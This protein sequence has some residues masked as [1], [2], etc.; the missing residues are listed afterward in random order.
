MNLSELLYKYFGFDSFRNAQQEIIQSLIEGN[1]TLVVMPTGGGKSLCYQLTSLLFQGTALVVSPLIALMKDQVDSLNKRNIPAA[2]LNSSQSMSEFNFTLD[3]ALNNKYKLL[4][5]APER[6]DS[7]RFQEILPQLNVSFLAVDE[8]HCISEWGHDFRPSYLEI[9][10]IRSFIPHVKTIA[11]TATATPEVQDDII[12]KLKINDAQR[13]IRGFDRANLSYRTIHVQ[14]KFEEL[15]KILKKQSNGSTIIYCGTRKKVEEYS[16]MLS[17]NSFANTIYHAGLADPIRKKNQDDFISGKQKIILATNAFGMGIDKPDV[18]NVIHLDMTQTLEAYYQEAGRAGRDGMP[19]NCYILFHPSDIFLQEFFINSTYP[20]KDDIEAL[21]ETIYDVHSAKIGQKPYDPII[22]DESQL[23]NIAG[24]KVS[25]VHSI[26]NLFE[27]YGV[28][29]KGATEGPAYIKFTTS[30][31]RIKEYFENTTDDRK[32]VLDPLLRCINSEAFYRHAS[33][34]MN[35][36]MQKYFLNWEEIKKAI[37]A[38]ENARLLNFIPPATPKG[39]VLAMERM[40]FEHLPIDFDEFYKRKKFAFEK[41][42]K[43]K[44]Y[45]DSLDCKRNFILDYFSDDEYEG[46]CAICSSCDA[47]KKELKARNPKNDFILNRILELV[48]SLDIKVGINRLTETLMGKKSAYVSKIDLSKNPLYGSLKE[49]AKGEIGSEIGGAMINGYLTKSNDQYQTI[50]ITAKGVSLIKVLP[51][52][53]V[54]EKVEM[55]HSKD[56][57]EKIYQKLNSLREEIAD[58]ESVVPRAIISTATLKKLARSAPEN[59]N[60]LKTVQGLGVIFI[61]RF[62]EKFIDAI[63]DTVHNKPKKKVPDVKII[64]ITENERA[65]KD[66]FDRGRN[67]QYIAANIG[68]SEGEIANSIIEMMDKNVNFIMEKQAFMNYYSK[69]KILMN[70]SSAKTLK[71]LSEKIDGDIKMSELKVL[72]HLIKLE[73]IS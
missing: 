9:G 39:I 64:K 21:Y 29:R 54:S 23:G 24:L 44:Q 46:K 59:L 43:V 53:F 57:S 7:P 31:E 48:Y 22:L 62:G 16:S 25:A 42:K 2:F 63:I 11:L 67:I 34:D 72:V 5:I 1:D 40:D 37:K 58:M 51:K 70:Y 55:R 32:K 28:I 26:L 71:Q 65:I 3:A 45:I 27:R 18:R 35:Y 8:A 61:N 13:F 6:L 36:F 4:F 12:Q 60:E 33:L 73:S 20:E 41:F 66:L 68:K 49:I 38:F 19:A 17:A 14:D 10:R 30:M 69:V 15:S 47:P 50:D 56:M 52:N